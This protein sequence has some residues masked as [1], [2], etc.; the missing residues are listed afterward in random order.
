MRLSEAERESLEKRAAELGLTMSDYIRD[1]LI[2]IQEETGKIER[3][4]RPT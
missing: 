2:H 3:A 4:A 1:K